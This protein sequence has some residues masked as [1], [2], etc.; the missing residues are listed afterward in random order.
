MTQVAETTT[1]TPVSAEISEE[2]VP[3][4]DGVPQEEEEPL[5]S[6]EEIEE[7]I[8]PLASDAGA[9]KTWVWIPIALTGC[10][11]AGGGVFLAV[12]LRGKKKRF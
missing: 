12:R 3:L 6:T 4:G 11:L 1:E 10:A 2:E 7:E 9:K 5:A 8:V